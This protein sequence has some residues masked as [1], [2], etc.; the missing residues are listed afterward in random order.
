MHKT[1]YHLLRSNPV[2]QHFMGRIPVV[3]ATAFLHFKNGSKTQDLLHLIKYEGKR[4]LGIYMGEL[5]AIELMSSGF[6]DEMDVLIP[7]PVHSKKQKQRGYNQAEVIAKG[8]GRIIQK[9][10][11][12]E[13]LR[14]V[15]YTLSQTTKNRYNRFENVQAS[16]EV[17]NGVELE[18]KHLLLFDDVITTGSTLEACGVKLLEAA[19]CKLSVL[20]LAATD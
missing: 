5:C 11:L 19:N 14:K 15:E 4:E 1:N 18:G 6:F 13:A 7:V 8:V 2:E 17:K 10:V 12:S 9:P 20:T 16:F 3:K